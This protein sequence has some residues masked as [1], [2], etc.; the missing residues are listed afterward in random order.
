MLEFLKSWVLNIVI[1]AVLIVLLEILIP[2]GKIKK[3]VNLVTGFVL[4]IAIITP[5]LNLFKSGVDLNEFQIANRNFINRKE[6]ENNSKIMNER[7]MSQ[8]TETYRN[9][10]INQL[11]EIAGGISEVSRVRAD[12]I[13]NEDYNSKT[14]G[15]IERAFL[16]V[17]LKERDKQVKPAAKIEKIQINHNDITKE[18]GDGE[19][20]ELSDA[21]FNEVK[22]KIEKKINKVLG[23]ES[24]SIVISF[25]DD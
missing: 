5:I 20:G 18:D 22:E 11:E 3:F 9:K 7:Q 6:I 17:E 12:V 1:L 14:F 13:I 10:I 2:S 16:Y 4:I 19:S 8:I 24:D 21:A 25:N 23:V 15:E